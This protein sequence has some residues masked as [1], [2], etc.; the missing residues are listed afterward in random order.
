MTRNVMQ[1]KMNKYILG[2]IAVATIMLA[3]MRSV[4]VSPKT[5]R[6]FKVESFPCSMGSQDP[7]RRRYCGEKTTAVYG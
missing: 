1:M 7:M 5:G 2:V 6:W 3:V 4:S